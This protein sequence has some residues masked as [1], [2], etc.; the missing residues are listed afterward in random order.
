MMAAGLV[1]VAHRSGGPLMD[2]V[3]EEAA[4]RNGFLAAN[5]QEY[6]S[7]IKHILND[8]TPEEVEGIRDRARD[9][10]KRFSDDQFESGWL[11]TTSSL[12]DP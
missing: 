1:T 12:I 7:T 2:I 8:L 6:A 9:S 11:R 4:V 10:V 5:E 3:I